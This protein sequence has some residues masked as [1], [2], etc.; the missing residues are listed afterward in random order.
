V[1]KIALI[2][3]VVLTN[4]LDSCDT[5]KRAAS[6]KDDSAAALVPIP[7][8]FSVSGWAAGREKTKTL[9]LKKGRNL[10]AASDGR[11]RVRRSYTIRRKS[12]SGYE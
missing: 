4:G 5:E 8:P 10:S 11:P 1:E 6:N 7:D 3:S 9:R 12:R 2:L